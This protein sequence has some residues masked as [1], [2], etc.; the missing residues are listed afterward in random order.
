M[1]AYM[2]KK[3][4]EW[5]ADG[6]Y[7]IERKDAEALQTILENLSALT[8]FIDPDSAWYDYI[9]RKICE[10]EIAADLPCYYKGYFMRDFYCGT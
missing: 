7:W 10:L 4:N 3:I 9:M 5:F 6:L 2:Y 1:K 8:M